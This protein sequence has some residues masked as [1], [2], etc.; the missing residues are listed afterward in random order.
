VAG[1]PGFAQRVEGLVQ[2]QIGTTDALDSTGTLDARLKGSTDE[3]KRLADVMTRTESRLAAKEKRLRAQFA[4]MEAALQASQT[5]GA[6]L[7]GQL[8]A[9][10]PSR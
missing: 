1:V 4:A 5:Q 3:Q 6:W 9:L 10:Q 8:A 2:Q 7:S